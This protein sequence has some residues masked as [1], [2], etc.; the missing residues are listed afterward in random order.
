MIQK[1]I[2][3]LH[4]GLAPIHEKYI[5]QAKKTKQD[6]QIIYCGKEMVIPYRQLKEKIVRWT[7]GHRDK[8]DG[9]HYAIAYFTWSPKTEEEQL[10]EM[11]QNG[12]FG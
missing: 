7:G 8:F 6:L 3:T 5:K 11:C 2:T 10:K 1:I 9:T 4:E 12:V